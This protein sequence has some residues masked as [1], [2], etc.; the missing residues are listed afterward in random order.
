VV[1]LKA[2]DRPN[3]DRSTD[4]AIGDFDL[5]SF[6][7]Y[8][9]RIFYRSVSSSVASV[10]ATL[11]G[12]SVSE[13]R[14]MAVLGTDRALSASEIVARSSMDK[15]NVSRAIQGLR[16]AGLLKRDI[17]G[18]D[19][20]RAVLRLTDQ[21]LATFHT[22]VPLV[23]EIEANLLRGLSEGERETLFRLMDKVR[24][25]AASLPPVETPGRDQE[26]T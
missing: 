3:V 26:Q 1:D 10:Y 22:L 19:R 16:K 13:W 14:T 2:I 20:R 25:N 15:V 8:R 4:Q 9:V 6:F 18:D 21:G 11:F 23:R 5:Q 7:P 24:E 17:D 12:L